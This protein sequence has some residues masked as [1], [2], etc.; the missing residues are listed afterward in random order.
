MKTLNEQVNEIAKSNVS[1]NQK[2]KALIDLGIC[3]HELSILLGS[4]K[5]TTAAKKVIAYTFG[6]EIECLVE[7]GSITNKLSDNNVRFAYEGYNHTDNKSY[8]KFVSDGSI[9][10]ENP[11]ECVS[12]V[13]SG[14][15]GMAKLKA[16]CKALNDASAKVNKSTGLHVHIGA[17][18]L[19][20]EAY[21][22]VFKNYQALEIV[23][24]SFM[25]NSRRGDNSCWCRTLRDYDF[26]WC[27]TKEDV[28]REMVGE[29]Y[30][31]VNPMSYVRHHTVE[32][33]QH[34][35]STDFEK[36]SMWVNFCAKLVEYSKTHVIT[37]G[38]VNAIAEI[39]FLDAKEKAFFNERKN[40]LNSAAL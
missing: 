34:Q 38:S 31:R 6:V 15:G 33:R 10:G 32:F 4:A 18:S 24:D 8:F 5:T 7:R 9:R 13:L 19:S 26:S 11:I 39:P 14:K 3:N 29:R 36:I 28:R 40:S 1:M 23:I 2:K 35:G 12:P 22:N 30:H 25:A 20:D 37:M 27:R 16:C 17:D 21:I